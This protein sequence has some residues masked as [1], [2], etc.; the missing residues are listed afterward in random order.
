VIPVVHT[1]KC[2]LNCSG[3]EAVLRIVG[4]FVITLAMAA[5]LVAV[6][7]YFPYRG[8]YEQHIPILPG[9]HN[10]VPSIS[11]GEVVSKAAFLKLSEGHQTDIAVS[12]DKVSYKV[13]VDGVSYR[14]NQS[15]GYDWWRCYTPGGYVIRNGEVVR[16][17]QRDLVGGV[18]P[19]FVLLL[20][21]LLVLGVLLWR[22][23]WKDF[24]DPWTGDVVDTR[25]LFRAR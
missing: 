21:V 19:G 6:F 25:R 10:P 4:L 14:Y 9:D 16:E 13:V 1:F 20:L 5:V 3:F 24:T 18:I 15:A 22:L 17:L 11:G 23:T 2:K 7:Y 12:N 8:S